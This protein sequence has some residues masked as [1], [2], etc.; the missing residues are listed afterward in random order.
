M[1]C[2]F[3]W[4]SHKVNFKF[5]SVT[6]PP[7]Q[8]Y[9]QYSASM[10]TSLGQHIKIL[11]SETCSKKNGTLP[12]ETSSS[13]SLSPHSF[14]SS[15]PLIPLSLPPFLYASTSSSFSS[16]ILNQSKWYHM[17]SCSSQKPESQSWYLFFFFGHIPHS[18]IPANSTFEVYIN[19]PII[20]HLLFPHPSTVIIFKGD[21]RISL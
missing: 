9:R 19:L 10:E 12:Y 15:L 13:P 8:R 16:S 17:L 1:L 20:F 7:L 18:P 6:L 21:C 14:F 11:N 4:H 2:P 3:K 5:T